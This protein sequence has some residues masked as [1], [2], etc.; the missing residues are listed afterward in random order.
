MN[1]ASKALAQTLYGS[2]TFLNPFLSPR[3]FRLILLCFALFLSGLALIYS[4]DFN[5]RLYSALQNEQTKQ[6]K[7]YAVY[8]QLL[9]EQT[10]LSSQA[11]VESIALHQLHMEIPDP[12]KIILVHL[13]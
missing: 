12:K 6:E 2:E 4:S 10:T 7:F 13:P 5:R 1:S 3:L 8:S 11:R 9:L